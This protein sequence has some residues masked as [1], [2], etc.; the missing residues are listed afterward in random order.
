VLAAADVLLVW[1]QAASMS[2]VPMAQAFAPMWLVITTTHAGLGWMITFAGSVLLVCASA[3]ARPMHLRRQALFCVGAVVAAA[4][5]AAIGHAADAGAFSVAEIV[6]TVHLLATGVWGGV[7]I[8]GAW[9]VLPA[10]QTSLARAFLIRTMA[11][12]SMTSL[13]AVFFVVATG[14]FNA[15]RGL[16]GSMNAL[17]DSTWGHVLGVKVTL[18][19]AALI[20]GA[21]SRWSALPRLQRTAST[22]DAHTVTNIMRLE[23]LLTMG[24]FVAAAVLSHSAP[25]FSMA[26]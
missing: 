5:K 19:L 11:R 6:Q 18:V 15:L 23:A 8:T 13:I 4:G 17:E 24:V 1:L 2:G 26:N 20:L 3:A 9:A 10:L 21:M 14:I 16:G 7:V 12:M 25:G 22:L